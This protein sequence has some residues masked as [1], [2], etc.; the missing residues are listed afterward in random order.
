LKNFDTDFTKEE[1]RDSVAKVDLS[2]LKEF[3]T[4]FASLNFN[5]ETEKQ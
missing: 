4:E 2:K 3:Q 1:V 5:I